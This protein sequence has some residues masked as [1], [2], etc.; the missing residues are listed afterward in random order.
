MVERR[1]IKLKNSVA[2]R[3]QRVECGK[4]TLEY[5]GDLKAASD[6]HALLVMDFSQNLTCPS[7]FDTPSMWYFLSLLSISVLGI[8]YANDAKQ[9][10]YIYDERV[11]GKGTD[12]VNSLLHDFLEKNVIP[13]HIRRLTV[14][15]DNCGGQNKS[16]HVI[17]FFLALVHQGLL[18]AVD[19]KFRVSGHTKNACDRGSG[20]IRN[21]MACVDCWTV[22]VVVKNVAAAA[23]S[24][25]VKRVP[26]ED[27]IFKDFKTVLSELYKPL[28]A[29]QK[30][31]IFSTNKES[32]GVITC[33]T[34]PDD[35]GISEDLRRY[36]DKVKT[37]GSKVALMFERY[38]MPLT[39][40]QPNAEKIDQMHLKVRPFVPSE[41]QNDPLYAAPTADE[42]AQSKNTKR[43]RLNLQQA[44]DDIEDASALPKEK[45]NKR[46]ST[47]KKA[48]TTRLHKVLSNK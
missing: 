10:N 40:P 28:S 29:V 2:T 15:A 31:H 21:R 36:I 9:Y 44:M 16:N 6:T 37:P 12:Q 3:R 27:N 20:R 19:F 39:P 32:S 26:V 38:L 33:R 46:A 18:G 42:A 47:R 4:K 25:V 35:A 22:D 48:K 45:R 8:Y 17:H 30:Y 34:H 5:K 1:R 41:F 24:S 23:N 43:A 13:R 7:I 11:S 14:Y